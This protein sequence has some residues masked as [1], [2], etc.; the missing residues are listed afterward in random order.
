MMLA[1]FAGWRCARL[2]A[3]LAGRLRCVAAVAAV[4]VATTR[5]A[6]AGYSLAAHA[7]PLRRGQWLPS[8][9]AV[10]TRLGARTMV[11]VAL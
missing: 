10:H 6:N 11:V 2:V 5:A 7:P 1:L 4:V 9:A 8:V 3:S